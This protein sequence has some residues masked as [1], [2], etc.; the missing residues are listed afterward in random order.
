[1][2]NK[3]RKRVGVS[4]LLH[5]RPYRS[6]QAHHAI[7]TDVCSDPIA[8]LMWCLLRSIRKWLFVKSFPKK[9]RVEEAKKIKGERHSSLFLPPIWWWWCHA[10]ERDFY[11]RNH[12]KK[13]EQEEQQ[14]ATVFVLRSFPS[15][16]LKRV[17][18]WWYWAR[19]WCRKILNFPP[20]GWK[21]KNNIRSLLHRHLS[22]RFR[23]SDGRREVR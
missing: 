1:M 18:F 19:F 5:V 20:L 2:C 9:I 13:E 15:C 17:F 14:N 23:T 21:G 4:V 12:R 8:R 11:Q 6:I 16:S 7:G 10:V 22:R 3:I